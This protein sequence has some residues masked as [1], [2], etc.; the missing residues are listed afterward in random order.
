MCG[1]ENVR[2][3]S[4]VLAGFSIGNLGEFVARLASG[5]KSN[6]TCRLTDSPE[7]YTELQI[8]IWVKYKIPLGI[9]GCKAAGF[10]GKPV[11]DGTFIWTYRGSP[12]CS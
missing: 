9:P 5:G 3:G 1:I 2:P 6:I 7:K 8:T 10:S 12:N 4:S 11:S